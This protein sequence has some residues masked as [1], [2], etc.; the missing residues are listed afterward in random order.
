MSRSLEQSD[1]SLHLALIP[2][3]YAYFVCT[4][5]FEELEI[6]GELLYFHIFPPKYAG[7]TNLVF[8]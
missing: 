7:R 8:S 2:V 6:E 5:R 4:F 1:C 3:C